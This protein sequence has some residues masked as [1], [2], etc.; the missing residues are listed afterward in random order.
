MTPTTAYVLTPFLAVKV[1]SA[2]HAES[3]RQV[4]Q[5]RARHREAGPRRGEGAEASQ[6][7]RE[8]ARGRRLRGG[9]PAAGGFRAARGR[10]VRRAAQGGGEEGGGADAVGARLAPAS[11]GRGEPGARA[12]G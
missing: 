3:A 5:S 1:C 11:A 8:G 4:A 2:A 6:D 7:H 9:A 10:A 12:A